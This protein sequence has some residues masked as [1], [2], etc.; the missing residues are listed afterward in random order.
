MLFIVNAAPQSARALA[1]VERAHK[2]QAY[3]DLISRHEYCTDIDSGDACTMCG[4]LVCKS[5]TA[6]AMASEESVCDKIMMLLI[7]IMWAQQ[8][9]D[10]APHRHRFATPPTHPLRGVVVVV[11]VPG[12]RP[13]YASM[14]RL[15]RERS[16]FPFHVLCSMHT[17]SFPIRHCYHPIAEYEVF[18]MVHYH[19]PHY[20]I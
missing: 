16:R 8:Y 17:Q 14:R 18:A 20:R 19:H 15:A 11:V 13:L 6:T 4:R 1:H 9:N 2:A 12:C 10:R 7:H 3:A 5:V